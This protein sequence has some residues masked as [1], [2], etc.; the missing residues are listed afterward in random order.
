[1]RIVLP[2][3]VVA[4]LALVER[5]VLFMRLATDAEGCGMFELADT[6]YRSA[7]RCSAEA[8]SLQERRQK[9]V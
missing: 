7:E 8:R 4:M 1:M 9:D 3:D 6:Y 5:A 2:P